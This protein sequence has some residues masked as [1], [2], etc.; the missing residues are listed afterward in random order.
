MTLKCCPLDKIEN[1]SFEVSNSQ[2][3]SNEESIGSSIFVRFLG[4]RHQEFT[5]MV[6]KVQEL[7]H[8]DPMDSSKWKQEAIENL[9]REHQQD[10]D[11][12]S[13]KDPLGGI[14]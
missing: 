5:G 1:R 7:D 3:P 12:G 9:A 4:T 6:E 14:R 2:V 11:N 13:Y 10:Y 8:T